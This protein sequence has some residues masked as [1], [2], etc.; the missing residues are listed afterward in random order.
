MRFQLHK[1]G[2]NN[3][4]VN[5]KSS[6]IKILMD[7]TMKMVKINQ[8]THLCTKTNQ[9][10][11]INRQKSKGQMEGNICILCLVFCTSYAPLK[12]QNQNPPSARD[13]EIRLLIIRDS[14]ITSNGPKI[15]AQMT[16]NSLC[17]IYM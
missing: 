6:H 14:F 12:K 11:E 8:M 17:Q 2:E 16:K 10:F 9:T 4:S 1:Y 5:S 3:A 15:E 7:K 13:Q